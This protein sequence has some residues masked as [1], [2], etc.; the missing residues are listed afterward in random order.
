[1]CHRFLEFVDEDIFSGL[2]VHHSILWRTGVSHLLMKTVIF[3]DVSE[4]IH[5]DLQQLRLWLAR[6]PFDRGKKS[7]I[8]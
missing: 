3:T 2:L 4:P 5:A 7:Q 8:E 6:L 1:M